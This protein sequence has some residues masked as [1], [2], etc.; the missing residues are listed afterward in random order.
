MSELKQDYSEPEPSRPLLEN[1]IGI[2]YACLVM[3]ISGFVAA[4]AVHGFFTA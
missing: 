2:W 4:L 1:G 3:I